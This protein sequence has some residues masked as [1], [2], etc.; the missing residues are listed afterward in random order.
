MLAEI[1]V[2]LSKVEIRERSPQQLILLQE[3]GGERKIPIAIGILEAF[4]I[5]RKLLGSAAPRPMT[6]D[7]MGSILDALDVRLEQIV[8][9]DLRDHTFFAALH[10]RLPDGGTQVIDAR[11]SD[12]IALAVQKKAPMFALEHVLDKVNQ[13]E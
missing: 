13:A 3:I 10:L 5:E 8:I 6:H 2:E 7:L 11:P 9:T 12:A 1:P 4:E